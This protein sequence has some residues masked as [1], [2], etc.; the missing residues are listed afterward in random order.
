MSHMGFDFSAIDAEL[1]T[2]GREPA[3]LTTLAR[4][5]AGEL[6]TLAEVDRALEALGVAVEL[7]PPAVRSVPR[8]EFT[9]APVERD[10]PLELNVEDDE[11]DASV[12]A[13]LTPMAS[14]E[15][16]ANV[17]GRT[18]KSGE[19]PLPEPV[20]R[21]PAQD[22]DPISGELALSP[23][24]PTS[25][26]FELPEAAPPEPVVTQEASGS[27]EDDE[28]ELSVATLDD[29]DDELFAS[30]QSVA[31]ATTPSGGARLKGLSDLPAG[32]AEKPEPWTG[33]SRDPDAEFDAI[34]S[35]ATSPS[36]LPTRGFAFSDDDESPSADELLTGLEAPSPAKPS[37]DD[38]LESE[39]H[40]EIIDSRTLGSITSQA[41]AD[42]DNP[43]RDEEEFGSTDFEIVMD[44]EAEAPQKGKTPPPPLPK[45]QANQDPNDKRPSFLGRIFGRKDQPGS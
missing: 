34:F 30:F 3:E 32:G 17:G 36:G 42:D 43:F 39:D 9:P 31:P 12:D 19:I 40:T 16:P 45:A 38:A 28:P 24:E 33:A 25:G 2:L 41:K 20:R 35:D 44:D 13:A 7:P 22:A 1:S 23:D 4:Q 27:D 37:S 15:P 11:L 29:E 14:M 8:V 26:S 6:G 10:L 5:Y 18:P 21:S